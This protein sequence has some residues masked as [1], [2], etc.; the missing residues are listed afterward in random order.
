[1]G[2]GQVPNSWRRTVGRGEP[3]LLGL[4]LFVVTS[5]TTLDPVF[6]SSSLM[7]TNYGDREVTPTQSRPDPGDWSASQP[8]PPTPKRCTSDYYGDLPCAIDA[9]SKFQYDLVSAVRQEVMLNNTIGASL[10]TLSAVA[11]Y[12]GMTSSG[13]FTEKW[14]TAAGLAGAGTYAFGANYISKP[15]SR[16]YMAAADAL[17]CV[18][19]ASSAFLY[20]KADVGEAGS[21][22]GLRGELTALAKSLDEAK[23]RLEDSERILRS[24]TESQSIAPSKKAANK[25]G[26]KVC[27]GSPEANLA[28]V[29]A[30]EVPPRKPS[31]CKASEPQPSSSN[32]PSVVSELQRWN[33]AIKPF[34]SEISSAESIERDGLRL[35][36]QIESAG[37]VLRSKAVAIQNQLTIELLKTEPDLG[38]IVQAAGG[39]RSM[40]FQL[41]GSSRLKP[42]DPAAK[43]EAA[44]GGAS[45]PKALSDKREEFFRALERLAVAIGDVRNTQQPV[46]RRLLEAASV[47]E[48]T[49]K[50]SRCKFVPPANQLDVV[51][52][53][54]EIAL[55]G[56]GP[57]VFTVSG[58]TG[59][60]SA[61]LAGGSTAKAD[62]PV[63]AIAGSTHS[64]TVNVKTPLTSGESISVRM[65][66]GSGSLKR[67]VKIV[68]AAT[69][70]DDAT[71]TQERP[72]A[73][74]AVTRETLK[75]V[76][77]QLGLSVPDC[78]ADGKLLSCRKAIGQR[79]GGLTES[80]A[81]E[82]LKSSS[83]AECRGP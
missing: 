46:R 36:G 20:R 77:G 49:G 80:E 76:C 52:D 18:G 29:G 67:V 71:P 3:Y 5:C 28:S 64:I 57:V 17:S 44:Y 66:D 65:A 14:L 26:Q 48:Q 56:S 1:M 10:I 58:G 21:A 31:E 45:V 61:V 83:K 33:E 9:V 2:R 43:A 11:A 79:S 22:S 15:R 24:A 75:Q 78:S 37:R 40:G 8:T 13:E 50:L 59:V 35:L 27:K 81:Q 70:G 42:A 73:G 68:P 4:C 62:P 34:R 7:L 63:V 6:V 19:L 47:S 39:V 41:T 16:V 12:K 69:D 32:N 38:A 54:D 53:D 51:P 30:L 23:R 60:P 55:S 82:I 74:A 25:P 72:G